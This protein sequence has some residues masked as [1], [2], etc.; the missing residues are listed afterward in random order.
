MCTA[1]LII[2]I[3]SNHRRMFCNFACSALQR[4]GRLD[5]AWVNSADP[6][7]PPLKQGGSQGR[8]FCENFFRESLACEYVSAFPIRSFSKKK[9]KNVWPSMISCLISSKIFCAS[10]CIFLALLHFFASSCI[11]VWSIFLALV[12]WI[13]RGKQWPHR[14]DMN[15]PTRSRWA[16]EHPCICPPDRTPAFVRRTA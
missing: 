4:V 12:F 16:Q 11:F 2:M 5:W 8:V 15:I 7:V 13:R 9:G 3:R 10:S 14:I 1:I 6:P